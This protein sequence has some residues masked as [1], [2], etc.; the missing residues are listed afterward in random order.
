MKNEQIVKDRRTR[1]VGVTRRQFAKLIAAGAAL[2]IVP[3]RVLGGPK[4][5]PPSDTV[6][7]AIIGCGGQGKQNAH[8]LMR[9]KDVK[10]VALADPR[11]RCDY[12]KFYY[13]FISGRLPLKEDVEKH[14]RRHNES[15]KC[16]DYVDFRKMLEKEKGID[17][18][19]CATPD[20]WHAFVTMAAIGAG[21]HVYCE[22]PLT[23]NIYEAR[24]VAAA[25]R[26]AGVATQM[27][28]QG[29]SRSHH[30]LACQW[31][32]DGAIGKVTEVHAWS[33]TRAIWIDGRGRPGEKPP[34][35]DGFDWKLWLGP[36]PFRPYHPSYAPFMWRGWWSFGNGAVADMMVHN[37]DPAFAALE[38]DKRHPREVECLRTGFVDSEVISPGNHIVWRFAAGGDEPPLAV[39]WYDGNLKPKRPE[40]LEK[41]RRMGGQDN[42]ILIV[43]QKGAIMGGGWS[44]AMRIIPEKKMREYIRSTRGK[45]PRRTLPKSRGHHRDWLD[46]CKGGPAPLSRFEYGAALTEFVLLGN[47]AVRA[48]QK[49]RWDAENMK[50]TNVPEAQKFVRRPYPDGWELNS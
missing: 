17:A 39:H 44:K 43:G 5:V 31:I 3:R 2:T 8:S 14:Y 15:F 9:H 13:N 12:H 20:H 36:R 48:K 11:E 45:E 18:V 26:E 35:P 10:I 22:K 42:G 7:V 33:N 25:A 38:L 46:A 21:K 23:H 47:V 32:W 1:P 40:C 37:V 24:T 28:N 6:N 50:V 4:H 41:G 29:R 16:A 34:V 49:I 30:R 19:L 27:G